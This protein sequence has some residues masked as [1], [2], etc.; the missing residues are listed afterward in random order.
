MINFN[1]NISDSSTHKWTEK[2]DL[3]HILGRQTINKK[4][5]C[6][7][8]QI[9]DNHIV[10]PKTSWKRLT[11]CTVQLSIRKNREEKQFSS[12][13]KQHHA[14]QRRENL[15]CFLGRNDIKKGTGKALVKLRNNTSDR[16]NNTGGV[17]PCL[18]YTLRDYSRLDYLWLDYKDIWTI[19]IW[20][21]YDVWTQID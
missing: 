2:D 21:T 5:L 6:L 19:P 17:H 11:V 18:D 7:P 8:L 3:C 1:N 16:G 4:T 13:N 20:T 9:Q 12:F 14:W 10:D 15:C